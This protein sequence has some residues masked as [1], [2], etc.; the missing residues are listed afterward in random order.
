M[1]LPHILKAVEAE[2][3]AAESQHPH[4]PKDLL[5]QIAIVNEEAG[6]ATRATLQHVYEGKTLAA[7][8]KE[9]FQTAAMCVRMLKNM[10]DDAEAK[11]DL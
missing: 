4:W 10:P 3:A 7:V 6:E 2:L 8:Q 11:A 5:H 1:D 9:L